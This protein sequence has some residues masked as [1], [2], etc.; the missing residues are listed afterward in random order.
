MSAFAIYVAAFGVFDNVVVSGL[1]VLLA[2]LYGFVA[3][4]GVGRRRPPTWLL[5][6]HGVIA[7]AMLALVLDWA[8]PDVRAGDLL[9]RHQPAR[10]TSS[11]GS[12]SR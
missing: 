12:R 8:E 5:V 11:P 10:R 7:I 2:L 6:L 1:T 4:R 9:R 3:W